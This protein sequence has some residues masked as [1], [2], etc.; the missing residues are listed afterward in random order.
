MRG[1]GGG[2][3]GGGESVA[4]SMKYTIASMGESGETGGGRVGAGNK[5]TIDDIKK[6][7]PGRQLSRRSAEPYEK[8]TCPGWGAMSVSVRPKR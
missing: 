2:N 8:H 3:W 6:K 7:I 1:R 4:N 5:K